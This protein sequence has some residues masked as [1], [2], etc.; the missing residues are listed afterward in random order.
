MFTRSK[1][2]T[3]GGDSEHEDYG[4]KSE[5]MSVK[6]RQENF[7]ARLK[8]SRRRKAAIDRPK[9]KNMKAKKVVVPRADHVYVLRSRIKTWKGI[10]MSDDEVFRILTAHIEQFFEDPES[11]LSDAGRR[12]LQALISETPT[13]GAQAYRNLL[14]H[15]GNKRKA[16]SCE[17]SPVAT[18]RERFKSCSDEITATAAREF[19]SIKSTAAQRRLMRE[20]HLHGYVAS[21]AQ[22]SKDRVW[23]RQRPR[24]VVA[25]NEKRS[26]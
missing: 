20:F 2:N 9:G 19:F 15:G 1:K 22:G 4:A 11:W 3:C 18:M 5:S 13:L 24:S 8:K 7:G 12:K 10:G 17:P 25:I 26:A 21:G 6:E 16:K 23:I 14:E